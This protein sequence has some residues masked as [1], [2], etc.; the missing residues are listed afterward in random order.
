MTQSYIIVSYIARKWIE[1]EVDDRARVLAEKKTRAETFISGSLHT[2]SRERRQVK[3]LLIGATAAMVLAPVLKQEFCHYFSFFGFCGGKQAIDDLGREFF[4]K[5]VKTITL[6]TEERFH[7]LGRLFNNTQKQLKMV[8]HNAN[9]N[10][11]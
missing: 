1:Y 5:T 6:E 2:Q 7:L 8:S 9:A 3:P 11:K 4:D 10:F